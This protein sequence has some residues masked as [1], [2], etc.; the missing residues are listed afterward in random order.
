MRIENPVLN[1]PQLVDG[2][3]CWIERMTTTCWDGRSALFLDRDGVI[4]EEVGYLGRPED[5]RLIVGAAETIRWANEASVPVVVVTNQAG[6]GRGYYDWAGFT[7]VGERIGRAL[8]AAGASIDAV[9]ACAYHEKARA[10]YVRADH[11]WRKPN[12]GMLRAARDLLG[13]DLGASLIVGDKLSDLAA[14]AAAGL[15]HGALVMT[16]HGAVELAAFSSS[17]YIPMTAVTAKDVREALTK[18]LAAGWGTN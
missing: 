14:G 5:V 15:S 4:V 7:A 2:I 3:G 11:P 6:L 13:V 9:V 1:Y 8:G 17:Q 16:G 18:A 12:P 10:P